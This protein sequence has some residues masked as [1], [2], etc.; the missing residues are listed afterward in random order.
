[1]SVPFRIIWFGN[2]SSRNRDTRERLADQAKLAERDP[3][4]LKV[5]FTANIK[6]AETQEALE[7]WPSA[8]EDRLAFAGDTATSRKR[9]SVAPAAQPA[10]TLRERMLA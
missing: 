4:A 9:G 2:C 3:T 8:G 5:Y 1:M 6:V 10:K 7:A